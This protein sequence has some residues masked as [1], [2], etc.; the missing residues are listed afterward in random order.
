MWR[1]RCAEWICRSPTCCRRSVIVRERSQFFFSLIPPGEGRFAFENRAEFLEENGDEYL[2]LQNALLH[3]YTELQAIPNKPD[4]VHALARRVE[5]LRVQLGFILEAQERNTV[6]WIERRGTGAAA[7]AQ[8]LSASH[9]DCR[10]R[11]SARHSVRASGVGGAHLGDA[12]RGRRIRVHPQP[13]GHPT[14]SRAGG[15]VALR[16]REPG[17]AVRSA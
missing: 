15:A 11:H 3:L 6:F 8:C 4:E 13:A 7:A 5:E 10:G 1:I 17:A 16:L 9:A 2:G 12:G 14:R